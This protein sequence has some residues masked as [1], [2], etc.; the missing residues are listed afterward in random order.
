MPVNCDVLIAGGGIVGLAVG[1]E[2]L[3]SNPKLKVVVIEKERVLGFHASGR[4]SGVLH[5]GFYYS[6]DS[7]KAKFCREG[8][9]ELRRLCQRHNIPVLNTGKIVVAKNNLELMELERLYLRGQQNGVRIELLEAKQ[10]L[11]YEPLARTYE[12]FLWSPTTGVSDPHAVIGALSKEF[13]ALGGIILP[14]SLLEARDEES[15]QVNGEVVKYRHFVNCAGTQADRIA[16]KFNV[17]KQF[18]MMPFMGVYKSVPHSQ[19]P[20]RSLVYPVPHSVNPFLGV[21]FT[22]TI[23]GQTKIGPTAIPVLGRENYSVSE[24]ISLHD[25]IETLKG[26]K[27]M[28]FGETHDVSSLLRTELPKLWKKVLVNEASLLVPS[29]KEING[30]KSRPPGIRAQLVDI[31]SGQLQQDFV[32]LPGHKSTHVLNAVSPGWTS[33]IPF[34]RWIVKEKVLTGL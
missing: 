28:V 19:L 17:G 15:I 8:N 16:K 27:S 29:A 25:S 21:H 34:G 7:L 20:L 31:N 11:D 32:V 23:N 3:V 4:N 9:S 33:A 10:L 24:G 18:T 2:L 6:P 13:I 22:L 12:R 26:F 5:A 1:K 30:W 14:N